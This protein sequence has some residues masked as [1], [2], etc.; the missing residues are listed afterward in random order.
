MLSLRSPK[1]SVRHC[2]LPSWYEIVNKILFDWESCNLYFSGDQL[3]II[4]LYLQVKR[5][6]FRKPS[7]S[8]TSKRHIHKDDTLNMQ[9]KCAGCDIK[10]SFWYL[11]KKHIQELH[12]TDRAKFCLYCKNFSSFS[13]NPLNT[14]KM[15]ILH[16]L[17]PVLETFLNKN[18]TML[19]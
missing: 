19:F 11:K 9:K 17:S 10:S 6:V 8:Q 14:L 13:R 1:R 16:L 12:K 15:F 4:R 3:A 2:E 18:L 7:K 5:K